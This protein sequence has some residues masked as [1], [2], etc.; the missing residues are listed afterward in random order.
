MVNIGYAMISAT[1]RDL[2][3]EEAV[4]KA[5]GCDVIRSE[6]VSGTSTQGREE[7][8]TLLQFLRA[9]TRIDRLEAPEQPIDTS[10]AAGK[11]FSSTR[12]ACL[13]SSRPICGASADGRRL[14]CTQVRVESRPSILRRSAS[15]GPTSSGRLR[16]PSSLASAARVYIALSPKQGIPHSRQPMPLDSADGARANDTIL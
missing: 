8:T 15:C 16:S 2:S 7:L 4:F 5:A 9:G 13:P 1:D 11:N 14:A 3:I 6:K 12:W 10:T